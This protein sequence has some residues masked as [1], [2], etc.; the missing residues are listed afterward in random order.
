MRI[1]MCDVDTQDG[2]FMQKKRGQEGEK[3]ALYIV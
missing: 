2:L 3:K 1:C